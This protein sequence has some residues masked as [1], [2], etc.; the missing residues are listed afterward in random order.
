M[1]S[2]GL[3][4]GVDF[5]SGDG[6]LGGSDDGVILISRRQ[7]RSLENIRRRTTLLHSRTACMN[8]KMYIII[9]IIVVV[10]FVV[11]VVIVVFATTF[12]MLFLL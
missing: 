11:V 4:G 10:V 6:F 7:P 5:G 2:P 1:N 8:G 3:R 12:V 9:I